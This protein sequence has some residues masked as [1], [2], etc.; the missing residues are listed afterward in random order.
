MHCSHLHTLFSEMFR[1]NIIYKIFKCLI[2]WHKKINR[3]A[4]ET[5]DLFF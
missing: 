3:M 2:E 1:G 4:I 5:T